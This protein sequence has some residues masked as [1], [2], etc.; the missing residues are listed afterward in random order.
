[1]LTGSF[2]PCPSG[3][4]AF[5]S[6]E[7][8]ELRSVIARGRTA[9]R[10]VMA[11]SC[12]WMAIMF[13]LAA[14]AHAT[15]F[16]VTDT[17]DSASDTNSLRYALTNAAAGDTVNITATGTITLGSALPAIGVNLTIT[18]PT[19]GSLIVSGANTYTVFTINSGATVSISGL[20]IA[21]GNASAANSGGGI[22]N[23][24]TLTVSDC[25][26]SSNAANTG[27]AI[28]ADA[29]TLTVVLNSTFEN[30]STS[31]GGTGGGIYNGGRLKVVNSTFSGNTATGSG[32]GGGIDNDN[33]GTVTVT[34][35]TFSDNSASAGGN[36]GG[37]F[38]NSGTLTVTNSIFSGNSAGGAGAGVDNNGGGTLNAN[39]NVFYQ[40]L[41]S[42]NSEDDCGSCTANTNPTDA[43]SQVVAALGSYG[44]PTQTLLPLPDA[45]AICAG[46]KSL[47]VDENGNP[48]TTDQRA[49]PVGASSYCTSGLVDAGAVQTNFTSIQ[50]TNA[51]GGYS[52]NV[53]QDAS[54]APVISVTE[55]G[56]NIGGVQVTLT[57]GGSGTVSGAMA[58]TVG[59]TGATFSGLSV[60]A[61]GSGAL[62]ATLQLTA[63]DSITTSPSAN[64]DVTTTPTTLTATP[65]SISYSYGTTPPGV[66]VALTP[67][68]ATGITVGDFTASLDG[69]TALTLGAG[70]GSTFAISGI[71]TTL[72]AGSHS[73]VVDFLGTTDYANSSVTIPL[74]VGAVNTSVGLTSSASSSTVNQQVT[75]TA[76]VTPAS[77]SGTPTGNVTFAD[78][79]TSTVICSAATLNSG[80]ASCST[81][82]LQAGQH[83]VSSV[84]N[85]DSNYN[86][87]TNSTNAVT[88]TVGKAN[89]SLVAT[90]SS[91]SS[92]VDQ[93]V[94]FTALV[95][96]YNGSTALSPPFTG[97]VALSG[98]V[99]FTDNGKPVS[100]TG[101]SAA[102]V[103]PATGQATCITSST[104]AGSHTIVAT[105]INDNNYSSSNNN[106]TQTVGPLNSTTA[107]SS[108]SPLNTSSINQSVTFTAKVTPFNATLG[109]T[110]TVSFTDNGNPVGCSVAWNPSTGVA[111]CSTASL[112]LGS[113]VIVA[114]YAG[115]S[116]Y[117]TS[118]N[119]LTQT[120]NP[121]TTG[122]GLTSSGS[123]STINQGVTFT[124]TITAPTG[125]TILTGTLSF[126]DNGS[127]ISGC[128]STINPNT[129]S[130]MC[131][132][133]ALA[134]GTNTIVA[135]YS[136][137]PNFSSSSATLNQTVNAAVTSTALLTSASGNTSVVDQAVDFSATVSGNAGTAQFTGVMSFTDNGNAIAN[138]SSMKVGATTGAALCATSALTRGA[139]SI[140]ATYSGD[141]DFK[142]SNATLTQTVNAAASSTVLV[143]SPN[144]SIAANPN[145]DDDLV[146]LT[147]T[148]TP[149]SGPVLLSGTVTFTDNGAPIAACPSAVPVNPSTG[150]ASCAT[151][152]LGFGTH[153]ILAAYNGD[154]NF[155]A[156]SSSVTQAVQDYTL[157]ASPTSTVTISQGF[158]NSTDPFTPQAITVS[159][160]PISGF[161]GSLTLT[162]NVV[163]VSAPSGA[164]SPLCTTSS[165]TL[166]I[167]TS[168]VQQ[169]VNVTVDAGSGSTPAATPGIYS[170]SLLGVDSTTGLTHSTASFLVNVRYEAAAI[171]IVSGAT[172]GNTSTVNFTLPA[173]VGLPSF[174]CASVT[175]PTLTSSVAP[176][177]LSLGC[178][179]SPVSISASTTTQTVPVTVTISTGST[180]TARLSD[181]SDKSMIVAA[182]MLGIPILALLGFMPDG[183]S[184][185]KIL[186]RYLGIVF[187]LVLLAQASGCGGGSF[188]APPSVTGLTPPGSYNILIQGTGTDN[189]VY[190]AVVQVN[191]TR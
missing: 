18:G 17:S 32:D 158:T 183:K 102:P 19:T 117:N 27:G 1:M 120:V 116:N 21:N 85:G 159:A 133:T 26:F 45:G 63:T 160:S 9:G 169:A 110:G 119:S 128:S 172:T 4:P 181:H 36:G 16:T 58:T 187:V 44:G 103:V 186:A 95:T 105:Y 71:P 140:A 76:T 72:K 55:N 178:S 121:A 130:A 153:T 51:S 52:A 25:T 39:H 42:N 49:F 61:V 100:G 129:G 30:N 11:A 37:I 40:N 106:V 94:T 84:Y 104:K 184:S 144:P 189:Q 82:L 98:A 60:N 138:C 135:T 91:G 15:T 182:G 188:T 64:L 12:L 22:T 179:F 143:S 2:P 29:G 24:G 125:T 163:P 70:S 31:T 65:S 97:T 139:H 173:N 152:T 131:T 142:T 148:V 112:A 69:S 79:S 154:P 115:D 80:Q 136:N 113:N 177:A 145:N 75:F 157:T 59:G 123:P 48:L 180:T 34:N 86:A 78:T 23:E 101:C 92:N 88:Q 47:A 149:S 74:T 108:S 127:P 156:S 167:T 175:G 99:A 126:T 7:T 54:P 3:F 81:S 150:I 87:S 162:C 73:I 90:S 122:L 67:S 132:T 20:T 190:Q 8:F 68:N 137:D 155:T 66:S 43:T 118:S 107:L 151:T 147:A 57:Y 109:L 77:G 83:I 114:T 168:A 191:V 50:F 124:A 10:R 174:Q 53:S 14:T 93:S 176:V 111:T 170:V 35:S 5:A 62:S 89:T 161:T 13:V 56:Q 141:P 33:N 46:Q 165:S 134:L 28:F 6:F 41:D 166:P 96:P 164:V 185:R 171:T 146:G 38:N